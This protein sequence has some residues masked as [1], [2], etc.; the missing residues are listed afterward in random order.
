MMAADHFCAALAAQGAN[1]AVTANRP[2]EKSDKPILLIMAC[3]PPSNGVRGQVPSVLKV[4]PSNVSFGSKADMCGAKDDVRFT[5]N[6][7]RESG[8][9]L[10]VMSAFPLKAD[11]CSAK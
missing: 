6:S 11:M 4:P 8:L 9:A 1:R 5:P 3:P 7:D 10:P 2:A